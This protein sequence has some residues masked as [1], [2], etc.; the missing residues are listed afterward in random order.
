MDKKISNKFIYFFGSFG[1]ILFGYDIG[2]MTGALPFLQTDWSL[3]SS[4]SLVGWITSAVMFG[5]IFG[6]ALAGQLSDR[7]GR[8]KVI[9]YSAIIFT[10][11]SVLS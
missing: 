7:L 5:A 10:L 11:G 4:S 8:R 2:V 3:S 6:G 1:G 9:L